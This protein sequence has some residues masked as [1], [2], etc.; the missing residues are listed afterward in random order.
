[1]NK[2][3]LKN[4]RLVIYDFDGV[5]TDNRV[6]VFENGKEAV[7]VNRADGMAVGLIKAM[8]IAQIIVSTET[9]PVVSMRAKK[10]KIPSMQSV[11]NK[12]III[13]K[14]LESN[15]INRK[16]VIYVGND[17]NDKEVMKFVGMPVAPADAD[18]AIR[19]IAKIVLPVKG[20]HGV[21]REL[22][23]KLKAARY[24]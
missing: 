1:M 7:L 14:Y 13:E 2:I 19:N 20:G 17:I 15:R 18:T 10:L 8:G 4:V 5:M 23:N 11:K 6:F 21:V 3:L 9:N 24:E 12:K 16:N 22:L